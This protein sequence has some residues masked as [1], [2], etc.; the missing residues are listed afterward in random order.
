MIAPKYFSLYIYYRTL[1]FI[2]SS[3][4]TTTQH[5]HKLQNNNSIHWKEQSKMMYYENT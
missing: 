3:Y 2:K 4:K 1:E 5:I